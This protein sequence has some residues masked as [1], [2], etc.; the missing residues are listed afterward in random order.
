MSLVAKLGQTR[1]LSRNLLSYAVVVP[2]IT[3]TEELFC[4]G[5]GERLLFGVFFS[6]F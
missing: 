2:L 1:D 3:G 6:S 4:L 5:G